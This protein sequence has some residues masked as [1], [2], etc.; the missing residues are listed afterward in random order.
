[1]RRPEFP[2]RRDRWVR[3]QEKA[4]ESARENIKRRGPGWGWGKS[5]VSLGFVRK[6]Q[7]VA[8]PEAGNPI[9]PGDRSV[10]L[11]IQLFRVVGGVL[12]GFFLVGVFSSFLELRL[13]DPIS[14]MRFSSQMTDRIPMALLGLALLFCHPRFFR[15]RFE[16]RVLRILSAAPLLLAIACALLIPLTMFSVANSFR[17]AT[18]GLEQQ[19]EEQLR[20]VRA[21]RDSTLSL[22]PDQQQAMVERYNRANP[23]K[24]PVD[25]E[26]F[27]KTLNQE[28][29]DSE[30]R[31]EQERQKVLETQK[32]KLYTAQLVQ[33]FKLLLGVVGFAVL[34][35]LSRWA[36]PDGQK[37]L[38]KE[39][40]GSRLA[41]KILNSQGRGE[42]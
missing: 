39:L 38:R 15:K 24:S 40:A 12:L 18:Y 33:S 34:W 42:G 8:D 2:V 5:L 23:R 13:R 10:I 25:L 3:G 19:V 37:N 28:V 17:N 27:L 32:R 11:G 29:R 36:R 20:G 6:P 21:V 30:A 9:T 22:S 41:A 26:G 4:A 7:S 35:R 14:E 16:S 1:M 31:L